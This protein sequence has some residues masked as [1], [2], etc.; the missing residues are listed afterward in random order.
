MVSSFF[1]CVEPIGCVRYFDQLFSFGTYICLS[2]C[3]VAWLLGC[4]VVWLFGCSVVRLFVVRLFGCLSFWLF[5][6]LFVSFISSFVWL[7]FYFIFW[8]YCNAYFLSDVNLFIYLIH[9]D[10]SSAYVMELF[11][12]IHMHPTSFMKTRVKSRRL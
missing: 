2:G 9:N 8:A 5:D 7:L 12:L 3:L 1:V 4:L 11:T 10:V 6:W